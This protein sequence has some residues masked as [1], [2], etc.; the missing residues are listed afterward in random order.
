MG[1]HYCDYCDVFLT[2]DSTSVRKA[3]NSGRNHLQ[4]VRD[5]YVGI[6]KAQA[7][8]II[9]SIVAN[10]DAKGLA[11]PQAFQQ[12]TDVQAMGLGHPPP[13]AG[14]GGMGRG[15]PAG[16]WGSRPPPQI[17]SGAPI[18]LGVDAPQQ[19]SGPP[20]GMGM[21][22]GMGVPNGM[23]GGPRAP[24]NFA[25]PP[26]SFAQRPPNFAQPPPGFVQGSPTGFGGQPGSAQNPPPQGAV[27]GRPPPALG[28]Q[29]SFSQGPPPVDAGG[30]PRPLGGY[31]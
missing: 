30:P 20:P 5:Y 3:H 23:A 21:P 6:D 8:A 27:Y 1:K 26:P 25:Q 14:P 9:N 18:R 19:F 10:Y 22:M 13:F 17:G 4:N 29:P 11:R 2:H 15:P 28:A 24:P 12:G 16:A 7:Q 31:R